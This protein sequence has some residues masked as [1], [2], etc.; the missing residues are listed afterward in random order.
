M[1]L[2]FKCGPLD[3]SGEENLLIGRT[4][5]VLSEYFLINGP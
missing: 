4:V 1:I 5:D 2:R 3:F